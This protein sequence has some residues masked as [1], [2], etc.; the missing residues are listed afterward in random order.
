MTHQAREA[1]PRHVD[2]AVLLSVE[3]LCESLPAHV[4]RVRVSVRI[5]FVRLVGATRVR[6]A[7][8]EV[9]GDTQMER[10]REEAVRNMGDIVQ[11]GGRT[12]TTTTE[13]RRGR[14]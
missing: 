11:E 9:T 5:V 6:R 8:R 14:R 2:V 1:N 13:T 3:P 10:V 4:A 7:E 12:H